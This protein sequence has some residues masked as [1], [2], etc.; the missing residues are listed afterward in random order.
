[1]CIAGTSRIMHAM[2]LRLAPGARFAGA[3]AGTPGSARVG[4]LVGALAVVLLTAPAE[5]QRA[6]ERSAETVPGTEISMAFVYLPR[7]GVSLGS[8]ADEPGRDDDE[9]PVRTASVGPLWV[10]IHEVTD[11]AY[12]AFRNPREP[13]PPG[14][15][16][17]THPSTPYEDPAHGMGGGDR[18]AVGMTREGA[19]RFARWLSLH[20]GRLYRLPTEAEWEYVCRAEGLD[21][22]PLA[23]H[24][25][26]AENA[27]GRLHE[28]GALAAGAHGVHDLLGNAAEWTLDPYRAD[29]YAGLPADTPASDPRAGAPATG[30]GVVRGGSFAEGA[31]AARCAAREPEQGAWK[32]RDPQVPKSR[33]WNTD[34]PH[35]GFRLVRDARARTLDE[36][37]AWWNDVIPPDQER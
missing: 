37:R 32:R 15:D 3:P 12:A 31:G 29:F 16:A 26:T 36:V 5:A 35:V 6:G 22:R 14:I 20:T 11:E 33:W 30:R 19:L 2:N 7:G 25:W 13:L 17:V 8:V 9:G 21:A 18:P 28:V 27:G 4:T 10:G 34:A 24:A 23:E 1:M